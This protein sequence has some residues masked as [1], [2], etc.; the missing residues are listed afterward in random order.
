[1]SIPNVPDFRTVPDPYK[2]ISPTGDPGWLHGQTVA[3][4]A[5]PLPQTGQTHPVSG[6]IFL[7][8]WQAKQVV[9]C[10]QAPKEPAHWLQ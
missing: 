8:H 6:K 7:W 3:I 5:T 10:E 2:V 4:G 9:C 1:M